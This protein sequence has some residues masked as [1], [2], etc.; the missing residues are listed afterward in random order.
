VKY[1]G[2]QS[3]VK[4]AYEKINI[5]QRLILVLIRLKAGILFWSVN[6]TKCIETD[7]R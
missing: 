2:Q 6:T 5:K 4:N 7:I 3:I 1:L